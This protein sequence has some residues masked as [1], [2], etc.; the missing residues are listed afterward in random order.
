[1]AKGIDESL[2][3]FKKNGCRLDHERMLPPFFLS[4]FSESSVLSYRLDPQLKSKQ[5]NIETEIRLTVLIQYA[6]QSP[7]ERQYLC[8]QQLIQSP[9]K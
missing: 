2:S 3:W 1:M 5:V 8:L 6:R 7:V 4:G 9:V